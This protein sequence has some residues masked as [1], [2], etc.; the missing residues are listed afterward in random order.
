[1]CELVIRASIVGSDPPVSASFPFPADASLDDLS[2]VLDKELGLGDEGPH[3]FSSGCERLDG[4]D[5]LALHAGEALGYVRCG[6]LA[7][8]FLEN[9]GR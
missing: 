8:V 4:S 1:M 7:S 9:G 3:S 6:R 5:R 2:P